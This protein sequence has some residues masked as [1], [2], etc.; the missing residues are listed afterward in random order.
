LATAALAVGLDDVVALV[1]GAA[2]VAVVVGEL[3]D[4][5]AAIAIAPTATATT[6]SQVLHDFISNTPFP[7]ERGQHMRPQGP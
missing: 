2:F 5:H 3:L 1:V 4:P 7:K 6:A